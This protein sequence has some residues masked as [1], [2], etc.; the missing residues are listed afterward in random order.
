[1]Y[2]IICLKILTLNPSIPVD[3]L[4]DILFIVS[5]TKCSVIWLKEKVEHVLGKQLKSMSSKESQYLWQ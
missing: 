5:L 4:L 2:L 1:M 3:L